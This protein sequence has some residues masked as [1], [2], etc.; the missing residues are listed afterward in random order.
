MALIIVVYLKYE[1]LWIAVKM[2]KILGLKSTTGRTC[3]AANAL[4]YNFVR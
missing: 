2:A 3:G 4:S 1:D